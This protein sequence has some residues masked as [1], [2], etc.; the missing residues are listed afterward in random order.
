MRLAPFGKPILGAVAVSL[1]VCLYFEALAWI[2]LTWDFAAR[3]AV[4][5]LSC[6][7]FAVFI[8]IISGKSE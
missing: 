3:G 8:T 1:A 4:F 2:P 6:I 7:M 5:M